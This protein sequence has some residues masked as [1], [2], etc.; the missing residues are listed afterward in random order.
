MPNKMERFTQRARRVLSLAQEEAERLRHHQIG[1]EH[2]LL[3]LMREEGGVAGRVLRDLGL[4]LRRVEELVSRLSTSEY[5]GGVA[6]LD[7]SPGT[8]KVLEL[9][10]DE[11]RRM[12]HHYIGTEHLLLGLVRQQEGIALDVLRRLGVNP[13]EIRRQTSKVLQESPVQSAQ[14]SHQRAHGKS[15]RKDG[16]P[17]VDQLSTD[18]TSLAESG[19]LDPVVG[20]EMEIERVIQVLSRRRKNNPALIGEPGVGKTAIVEGLAQR[21]VEGE[22][23]KPLLRKRVLQL[24]VGS[25]VAGTMYRGQFE[26]RLKRVIE[27]LKKSDTILFIDEVH[28]LV[29]AGAAGSSVDAANI[30]KPALARGELQCIGATT[31]DEYRKHVE[32]DAAL[33]RRFQQI[34]VAEPTIEETIEILQG[35]KS[36]YQDHHNVEITDDAIETAANLS[37][38]YIPDRYLPDKAIDLIDEAAARLRMYKSPDAASVRRVLDEL[39]GMDDEIELA[40]MAGEH[41]EADNLRRRQQSLSA[42][43]DDIKINW[44]GET[45]LPRLLA[46]DISEVAAMWTGIPVTRIANEESERLLEMEER[47]HERIVGQ[48]EAIVKISRAVRRARAGLKDPRRPIGSFM[49]LGPTGVG[50]TELT[51]ALAEFLFGSEDA[52]IQL[53]MSEFMERHSVARLVGAPPGYVGYDDAGQLTEAVRRRPYSIIVFDEVEKAHP[54][55]FNMLLQMM[56]EGTLTDAR[57]RRVDFR[58]AMLVM[59]SNVGA[60]LIKPGSGLGFTTSRDVDSEDD[61]AYEDMSRNVTDQLQRMFRPE[62]LN[63]VDATIIFRSL[64]RDEIKQIVDLELNKVRERLLEHA[65]TLEADDEALG[66][67]GDNGYNPEFGARPLR[68]LI[69]NEI[70]DRLSDGILTGEFGLASIARIEVNEDGGLALRNA[71]EEEL[72]DSLEVAV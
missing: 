41:G 27:E 71:D 38:R 56:E 50:K 11:A 53:D 12:G 36:P 72:H 61:E 70:E 22:T 45:G 64:S 55:V 4:D 46:D 65:I 52:L 23:P 67:L 24:D 13:D 58:N 30:L 19:K 68:R 33:E 21:I 1:T 63:R 28:M 25:L 3:G 57:G 6:Q 34:Q 51:K 16:T 9:A 44:N 49:F 60:D 10:V 40:E 62:F 29:G 43:L 31:L 18:L 69:Q 42:T 17:L 32:S 20:R 26:E 47:L 15:S 14:R 48:H 54:E 8:K 66:W 35:I 37:A 2:L 5:R 39:E 7:L 59:T